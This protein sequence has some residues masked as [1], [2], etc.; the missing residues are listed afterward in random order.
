MEGSL[1]GENEFSDVYDFLD[2]GRNQLGQHII[3]GPGLITSVAPNKVV[4][5]PKTKISGIVGGVVPANKAALKDASVL[6]KATVCASVTPSLFTTSS[7]T[8]KRR[9]SGCAGSLSAVSSVGATLVT[10]TPNI[11]ANVGAIAHSSGATQHQ[12]AIA[13]PSVNI[14]GAALT[15]IGGSLVASGNL[16]HAKNNVIKDMGF[17]VTGIPQEALLNGQIVNIT[18]SQLTTTDI[19]AN[20]IQ[21]VSQEDGNK[22]PH[23]VNVISNSKNLAQ[24][25]KFVNSITSI[26]AIRALQAGKSN[27]ITTLPP[28]AVL[29]DGSLQPGTML[30][31]VTFTT[32]TVTPVM[33]LG[34]SVFSQSPAGCQ[35][36]TQPRSVCIV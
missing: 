33:S 25:P 21:P 36:S 12:F 1:S 35:P 23:Q 10:A 22:T 18:N 16:K 32:S 5:K 27:L 19:S 30:Q 29:L 9:G 11:L 6:S 13:I 17:Y 15:Q 8:K 24:Q 34:N 26:D 14:S 2:S 31:Q 3:Q 20:P 7:S 28:N 4:A